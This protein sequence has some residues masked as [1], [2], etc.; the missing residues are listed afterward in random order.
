[1]GVPAVGSRWRDAACGDRVL[2]VEA[3][4]APPAIGDPE[5]AGFARALERGKALCRDSSDGGLR[6]VPLVS[7]TAAEPAL[8]RLSAQEDS[9]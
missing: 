3:I 9:S 4:V 7:F 6:L 5:G 8:V 2:T 1:M